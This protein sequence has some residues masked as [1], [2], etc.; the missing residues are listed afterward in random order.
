M[1][2]RKSLA[3]SVMLAI[4]VLPM[5]VVLTACGRNNNPPPQP[6]TMVQART[7]FATS[8]NWSVSVF[9]ED[10]SNDTFER[11]GNRFR[12]SIVDLDNQGEKVFASENIFAFSPGE[13]IKTS[14]ERDFNIVEDRWNGWSSNENI[15]ASDFDFGA[16]TVERNGVSNW[17]NN[18][19]VSA[20]FAKV[21]N[22]Y[23]L[24]EPVTLV[25]QGPIQIILHSATIT[26]TATGFTSN[27]QIEEIWGG[28]PWVS[29]RTVAL[30]FGDVSISLP[31]VD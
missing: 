20:N 17:M 3:L 1:R 23:T 13:D 22:T 31:S 2:L 5:A 21:G 27:M 6:L 26:M 10:T 24:I 18:I 28:S 9:I 19:L 7:Q 8:T 14:F 12:E 29:D 25:D 4:V 30:Q 11:D 15:M 16:W